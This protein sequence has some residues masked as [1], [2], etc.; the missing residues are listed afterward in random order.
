MYA[1]EVM[2]SMAE[3]AHMTKNMEE[4]LPLSVDLTAAPPHVVAP[5]I[6]ALVAA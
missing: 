5:P 3:K 2:A 4:E 1:D 6:S